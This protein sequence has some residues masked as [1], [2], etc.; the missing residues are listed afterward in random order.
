[1]LANCDSRSNQNLHDKQSVSQ[2]NFP[3]PQP[4]AFLNQPPSK[5]L[6][7]VVAAAAAFQDLTVPPSTPPTIVV[8]PPFV[9]SPAVARALS[10]IYSKKMRGAKQQIPEEQKNDK[11][12][13]RRK[14]NNFAA[15]KSRDARKS[16]E[17][18]IANGAQY[19][20]RENTILRA[21]VSTLREEAFALR[22]L[23][24]CKRKAKYRNS[25]IQ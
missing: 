23:L 4:F 22:T 19:M 3:S 9:K 11:Y 7:P 10:S 12:Y 5:K 21:Q 15:K 13:E 20:E 18:V 24:V 14:R 6:L 17:D 25:L 2:N 8:P 1:M 16:R